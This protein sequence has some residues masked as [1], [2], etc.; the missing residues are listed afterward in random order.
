MAT[1]LSKPVEKKSFRQV[2]QFSEVVKRQ[3]VKDIEQGKCTVLEAS[4]E[5]CVSLHSVYAWVYKY[6]GYLQKSKRMVVQD[7]SESYKTKVLEI[8]LREAEAALG[9]KQMELDILNKLV[10]L[11]GKE[12]KIDLKKNFSNPASNGIVPIKG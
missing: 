5:L 8:K 6:S 9:R 4:R 11:A 12:L 10:E 3:T 7:V 1:K 2:K